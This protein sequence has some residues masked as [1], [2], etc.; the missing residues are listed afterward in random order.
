MGDA[1][2]TATCGRFAHTRRAMLCA[3]ITALAA[4]AA[5]AFAD[6]WPTFRHD[7]ARSGW[8]SESIA[9][10]LHVRW[11]FRQSAA[12][13][14]VWSGPRDEAVEGNWEKDRV[15]FDAANQVAVVGDSVFMG[16]SG[17]SKVYCLD[18]RTGRARW[19]FI[20]GAPVRLAP[21]VADGRV[22]FGSDDGRAY[23]LRADDGALVWSV[24]AGPE[25]DRL[26]GGGR[27]VSRWPVRTGVLVDDG[28]AYFAAGVFPHEGIYVCAVDAA[29]GRL[30]WRNDTTPTAVE[31]GLSGGPGG[32]ELSPQGHLLASESR[33]FV[34]SGRALPAAFDRSDGTKLFQSRDSWRSSGLVGG[35]FAVLAGD[36]ILVGANQAV[37]YHQETGRGGFAWFPCRRIVVADEVAYMTT[38]AVP[39][40]TSG[41][42]LEASVQC[43][44]FESYAE[45]TRNKRATQ[46]EISSL[47]TRRP[48][49]KS[50]LDAENAKPEDERN[51]ERIADLTAQ[52][53]EI[54]AKLE[55]ARERLEELSGQTLQTQVKWQTPTSCASSLILA[56][57]TLF[58]GGEGLVA[59]YDAATGEERWSA[60]IEGEAHGLAA[61]GG[62]LYVSTDAGLLYCF[63]SGAGEAG[64]IIEQQPAAGFPDDAP[65]AQLYR[66]AADAIVRASGA[67]RGFC[68][69]AGVETGRLALELARRTELIIHCLEPDAAKVQAARAALDAAGVYGSRVSVDQGDFSDIPYSNYFANLIVSERPLHGSPLPEVTADLIRKLKP[70]GGVACVGRPAGAPEGDGPDAP[71]A[72]LR[73][74][75]L[76]EP[77]VSRDAGVWAALVRGELPGAGS[78]THQ[79]AVPGNTACGD[80]QVR[81]PLRLLWYGDPGPDKMIS[82]HARSVAPLS[83]DG[84]LL[85]QGSNVVMCYDA[86]NGLKYWEREIEGAMRGA[87]HSRASNI[88]CNSRYMFV[89]V[90]P[91]CL[92]LNVRTGET[93]AT[94]EQ[95]PLDAEEMPGWGWTATVGDLLYGSTSLDARQSSR[96]F[97]LDVESGAPRWTYEGSGITDN[98]IAVADGRVLFADAVELS[99]AQRLQATAE[100]GGDPATADV[101]MAVCLDAATGAKLWER[102]VDLT[103]CGAERGVLMAMCHDGVLVFSAAHWNGH[104]WNQFLA[105]DYGKRRAV[106]LAAADG[107]ML[108]HDRLG[109]RIRPLIIG[110]QFVGEPWFYDLHTGEQRVSAHPITGEQVPWQFERPGHHCGCIA[111]TPNMLLFRS[112]YTAYY[113]LLGDYGSVHFGAQRPGCWINF[114]AANGLVLVQEASSGCQC[115]YAVQCTLA[116]EPVEEQQGWGIYS[117]PGPHAPIR[118][119]TLNLGAPGDRRADDGTLWLSWPRPWSR[120][121]VQPDLTATFHEGGTYFSEDTRL[122]QVA[123]T[124]TP[125]LYCSGIRGLQSLTVPLVQPGDAPAA[126]TVRLHLLPPEQPGAPSPFDITLQ[127]ETVAEAVTLAASADGVRR[128]VIR[129]FGPVPVRSALEIGLTT[130]TSEAGPAAGPALCAIEL[131][132]VPLPGM[133]AALQTL[134]APLERHNLG[135]WLA[136]TLREATRSDLAL[137]PADALWLEGDA[138]PAGEL[139]MGG[140]LAHIADT[141]IA[142]HEVTGASL[143]EYFATPRVADRLNPLSHPRSSP[144]PDALYHSGLDVTCPPDAGE[145]T[146]ALEPGRLYTL[147]SVCPFTQPSAGAPSDGDSASAAASIPSL[148]TETAA[149]LEHTVWQVL[150]DL[151]PEGIRLSRRFPQ[152]LP[153]WRTWLERAEREMGY[154]LTE[155]PNAL[156]TVTINASADA[157]VRRSAPDTNF[158]GDARLAEDG[159][160]LNLGDESHALAYLRFPLEVPGRPV[161]AMLRLR[162]HDSSNSQSNDAGSVHVV[163]APWSETEITYSSRPPHG[164]KV[165][166][167]GAVELGRLEERVL[168]IDLRGRSEVSLAIVPTSTDAATFRSRESD[169]PP[170]LIVAYEP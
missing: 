158:G 36:H 157:T 86:Y 169:D 88:C 123:D 66:D 50:A 114:I 77:S 70:C 33:L 87:M 6:D 61:A 99:D 115:L 89:A 11:A 78:W 48:T 2:M 62:A 165:G 56:G 149:V 7:N 117:A 60:E 152:P 153:V 23:C 81:C 97:A 135:Y 138:L 155:W 55:A 67:D 19:T 156:P 164:E 45:V 51:A 63:A 121:Q 40:D 28:A 113:D 168:L 65:E 34:P 82:R 141:R 85:M 47:T 118:S 53:E 146:V 90:G 49:V 95:P 71:A 109:Y 96:I 132:R 79:Y 15:A 18:A 52:F 94:F 1:T 68:L 127:G 84:L 136:D 150:E 25:D 26:I 100:S 38:D 69:V 27:M 167:L 76:G 91:R 57:D 17:D 93:T 128:P 35:T 137:I 120:M 16:S 10:P 43:V 37:G 108:W 103:D 133:E 159:G 5:C 64:P 39:T 107:A 32:T 3:A 21:A 46:R 54:E 151:G 116:F 59:G 160:N 166:D 74:F 161:M 98:T 22:Y 162:T 73:A 126:Y 125:W 9:A 13:Q 4:I 144:E 148:H 131:R 142:R 75:G 106:A 111:G 112:S 170:Q 29:D 72:W 83:I 143:L 31:R 122:V 12:P 80:D 41:P 124:P 92:R 119:L 14:R 20:A 105:G 163:D 147:V 58:A 130:P 110:D 102:P 101:R 145:I 134:E 24:A 104:Y 129:Q 30:I 140:L 139:T 44:S 154:H 42:A 8:T